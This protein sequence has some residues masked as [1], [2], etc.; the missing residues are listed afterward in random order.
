[1]TPAL[2]ASLAGL[3]APSL[4]GAHFGRVS[5]PDPWLLGIE[6]PEGRTLGLC[7]WP[8]APAVGICS[9]RWPRTNA[10]DLL[11]SHLASAK[12]MGVTALKGEPILRFELAGTLASALVWE[13]LGRSSNLLLLDGDG[14]V[15]WSARTLGGEF[16]TGRPGEAWQVPPVR[17]M[18]EAPAVDEAEARAHLFDLAPELLKGELLSRGRRAALSALMRRERALA[19]RREAV[20]ADR[21][22]GMRWTALEGVAQGL[23]A[24]GGINR[25]GETRRLVTDFGEDPPMEVELSLD[26]AKTVRANA[27]DLFKK[28]RRGK[29]RLEKTGDLLTVLAQEAKRLEA[30]RARLENTQDLALLF[31]TQQAGVRKAPKTQPRRTLPPNVAS[32]PLPMDFSAYAG[33]NA[34][35]NDRVSFRL[36]KGSDFWFH[37]EDYAGCH[38]VVKNPKRLDQLPFPVE[39]SAAVYAATHSGARPGDRVAVMVAQCKSLR[40]VPGAVGRVMVSSFRT[41]FVDLPLAR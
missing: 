13:G 34:E 8:E 16:R 33:K 20:A 26:P 11:R 10:P 28:V 29:A 30:E 35:G 24:S 25:R 41:V 1:M 7:W 38:V 17:S 5:K 19:R 6:I 27:E 32:V 15:L 39:Q 12:I 18:D 31:P 22:E 37:A 2:A 21:L 4:G 3:L 9:W 23:I 36:G 40:R 14:N